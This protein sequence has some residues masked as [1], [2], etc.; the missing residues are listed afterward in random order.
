MNKGIDKYEFAVAHSMEDL[1]P[2]FPDQ[3]GI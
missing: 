2:P 1:H 3:T